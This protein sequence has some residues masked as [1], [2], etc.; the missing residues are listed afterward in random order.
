M[1]IDIMYGS[2]CPQ[3]ATVPEYV[4]KL[5]SGLESAYKRVRD[6]M[7]HA[8]DRQ[9]DIY[10]RKVHGKPFDLGDWVWLHC[11]AVPR[12][13]SKKL[14]RPWSGPFRVVTKL[15]E[16]TYRI[17]NTRNRRQ[18]R[19]VHFDRLKLCPPNMRLSEEA[20][21]TSHSAPR[22]QED[23]RPGSNVELVDE[24]D[25]VT[26]AQPPPHLPPPPVQPP[27]TSRYPSRQ[28]RPPAYLADYVRH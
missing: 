22:H 27:L 4:A 1:P 17:Q 7:G 24:P 5:R 6:Q 11:P 18:R 13:Q 21:T 2:P 19:V 12:G 26:A 23:C 14:H 8:L 10:D 25:D 16:G 9:K 3:P 20:P 28:R 15:S